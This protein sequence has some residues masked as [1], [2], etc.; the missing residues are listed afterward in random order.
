MKN[1]N[2]EKLVANLNNKTEYVIHEKNLKQALNS[3]LVFKT[4]HR[5]ITFNQSAWLRP[6]F[7]L[8]NY[9]R[10]KAQNYFENYFFKLMSNAV[11]GKTI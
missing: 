4:V 10:K 3:G 6:Y 2:V 9:I 11:F 1:V 5:V 7:D 8:N